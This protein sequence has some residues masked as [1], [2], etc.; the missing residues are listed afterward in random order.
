[1]KVDRVS[2]PRRKGY[3]QGVKGHLRLPWP[4]QRQLL[5]TFRAATVVVAC[6]LA[7]DVAVAVAVAYVVVVA[8]AVNPR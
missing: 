2:D 3:P 6:E 1:M 5:L 4:A 8:V 7:V